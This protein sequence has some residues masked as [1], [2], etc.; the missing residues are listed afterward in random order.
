MAPSPYDLSC[1]W[2]VIYTNATTTPATGAGEAKHVKWM[3]LIEKNCGVWELM[4]VNQQEL[5]SAIHAAK[6]ANYLEVGPT[7]VDGAPGPCICLLI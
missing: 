7:D 5:R 6:V 1:W 3:K 2:E 4:T